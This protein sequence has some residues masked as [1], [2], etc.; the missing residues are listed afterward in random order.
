MMNSEFMKEIIDILRQ[1]LILTRNLK[2]QSDEERVA[3]KTVKP[4]DVHRVSREMESMLAKLAVLE[5]RQ[6]Q[7]LN[8]MDIRQWLDKQ[9]NSPEREMAEGLLQKLWDQLLELKVVTIGNRELLKRNI[10]YIDYNVNVMT[11]TTA[12]V[13]YGAPHGSGY[14]MSQQSGGMPVQ[15]KKMFEAGV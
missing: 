12:G 1:Q 10:E 2:K 9:P 15:G 5:K 6:T 7:L 3:L 14:G 11:Q 8:G 13:T 4:R